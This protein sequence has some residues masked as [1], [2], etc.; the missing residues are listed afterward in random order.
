MSL[1]RDQLKKIPKVEL[2]RHLELSFRLSTLLE[3]AREQGIEVPTTEAGIR[4]R[5]L[6]LEPMKDLGSVLG[7]FLVS[8]QVLNSEEVITRLTREC[9][10]DCAAEGTRIVEL[11]YAPTFIQQGHEN[12][13]YEQ[14]H[15]A[16]MKGVEQTRHL[17]IAVGILLTC[18]RVLPVAAAEK[19]IG[20]AI[21]N[22]DDVL[23]GVDLADNE[24]DSAPETFAKTFQRA[25]RSGLGVTIHAGES[26]Y[27]G[28]V[29][30]VLTA[31]SEL[32]ARRIGHGLQIY[33]DPHAMKFVAEKNIVLELCPTSNWLTNAVASVKEHPFRILMSAG[34]PVTINTDDPGVFGIDLVNEYEVLARDHA[35]TLA[36]FDRCNDTAARA[37]FLSRAAK[38]KVWPRTLG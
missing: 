19:V 23:V 13:S 21:A 14:I 31:V 26:I 7:K 32:Q 15:G 8:Q 2:H 36:E 35:F 33:R 3:L 24:I 34:V 18:Q 27:P 28:M 12:L 17:P 20:F 11:R 10:E 37:S 16:V 6:V 5:F 1:T 38:Q 9:I 4:D 29:Q 25:A 30:S 22:K